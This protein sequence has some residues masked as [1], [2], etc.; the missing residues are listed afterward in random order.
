MVAHSPDA[1][2]APLPAAVDFR[3]YAETTGGRTY[4]RLNDLLADSVRQGVTDVRIPE[5]T[6]HVTVEQRAILS[7]YEDVTLRGGTANA[8]DT[9]LLYT[10]MEGYPRRL[11]PFL[12]MQGCRNITLRDFTI[13]YDPLNATQGTI[14][15]IKN[16]VYT[17]RVHEGYPIVTG[18]LCRNFLFWDRDT[19]NVKDTCHGAP[20]L[21]DAEQGIYVI[22][23]SNAQ[24]LNGLVK[25]GDYATMIKRNHSNAIDIR[26]C[27]TTRIENI[28]M[29]AAGD[30]GIGAY[31]NTGPFH[32]KRVRM[33]RGPKPAGAA[34]ERLLTTS[35]DGLQYNCNEFGPVIEEC[36]FGYL[37]DDAIH[38]R[39]RSH[40]VVEILDGRTFI[41]AF[42]HS[43][44]FVEKT[45][46]DKHNTLRIADYYNRSCLAD[47]TVESMERHTPQ[48][49]QAMHELLNKY[50]VKY[51]RRI[52]LEQ[53]KEVPFYRV[54]VAGTLPR[55]VGVPSWVY[56]PYA[57]STPFVIRDSHFH[58]TF[59][60]GIQLR[61]GPGIVENCRI[62]HIPNSAIY[63]ALNLPMKD[64]TLRA[65]T[66]DDVC[67]GSLGRAYDL[68]YLGAIDIYGGAV[69]GGAT[70]EHVRSA[71]QDNIRIVGNSITNC[72][73]SGIVVSG[74]NGLII[75]GNRIERSNSLLKHGV[76]DMREGGWAITVQNSKDVHVAEDNIVENPGEHCRGDTNILP[77]R[78]WDPPVEGTE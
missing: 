43:N 55:E 13:D 34:Q 18:E 48:S 65:N 6:Y 70:R 22:K 12:A 1:G 50:F 69:H 14:S 32:V 3:A 49:I 15:E 33:V 78:D 36:E 45:L 2:P 75:Q 31:S 59:V 5:G 74:A 46:L 66:L 21:V 7:H 10:G 35:A 11:K 51:G 37:G 16:N 25:V 40:E 57:S 20:S 42:R 9:R 30:L 58:N 44:A 71:H 47:V 23:A 54:R 76:K 27:D 60:R 52:T 28:V 29:H 72:W 24:N 61:V 8:A 67:F 26:G 19:R 53:A 68:A 38:L 63:C 64:I 4:L 41:M 56:A 77:F 62:E 17:F 73:T 39:T